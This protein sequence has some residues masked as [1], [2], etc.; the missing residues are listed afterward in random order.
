MGKEAKGENKIGM[1][2]LCFPPFLEEPASGRL[3]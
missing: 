3:L 1:M 2:N